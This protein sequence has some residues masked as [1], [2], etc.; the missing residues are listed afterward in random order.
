MNQ[1]EDMEEEESYEPESLPE[2]YFSW[3]F[4]GN[5]FFVL[6]KLVWTGMWVTAGLTF[7]ITEFIILMVIGVGGWFVAN[8]YQ[9]WEIQ[10]GQ[11]QQ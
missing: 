2:T 4:S 11:Q 1:Q 7:Q 9:N 10:T 6:S 8:D 3:V 5:I